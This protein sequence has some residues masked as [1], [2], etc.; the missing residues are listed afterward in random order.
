MTVQ[1]KPEERP[2][3]LLVDLEALASNWRWFAV[4]SSGAACGA[5]VKANAYGV[6]ARQVV[7][8]L[9]AAG[10]RDFFVA[11]WAELAELGDLPSGAQVSVLHG[12]AEAEMA[13]AKL[14]RAKPVLC[15]PQQVAL[16]RSVGD[17]PCDVMIDTGMNRLGLTPQEA[18][19]GMLD[20]LQIDTVHSHLACADEPGHQMNVRQ[21]GTLRSLLAE[22]AYGRVAIANSAGVCLGKEYIF[23][24]TRPG[25]GLYGGIVHPASATSLKRVVGMAARIVQLREVSAGATVG[26]N[27][28]FTAPGTIKLA[29]LNLGYADGLPRSLGSA[30]T[31]SISGVECAFVGRIS[32]D[33]CAVDVS[34]LASPRVGDWAEI[35]FDLAQVT[36]TTGLSPYELLTGLGPRFHRVFV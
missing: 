13:S 28:A 23:D 7:R 5:A 30:G 18:V 16:W 12:I 1:I 35:A 8:R 15:S 9:A 26:Y 33:L 32:M 14:S 2:L 24:L 34:A 4:Q 11:T 6:G 19:S 22:L 21:L 25:I 17:L 20:G 3:R 36:R 10:C 27:A 29:I 31:A